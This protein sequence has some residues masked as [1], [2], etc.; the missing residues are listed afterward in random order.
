MAVLARHWTGNTVPLLLTV[1]GFVICG[2][3]IGDF[4]GAAGGR[5][6]DVCFVLEAPGTWLADVS[7]RR[8]AF[9][10]GATVEL[11]GDLAWVRKNRTGRS[12][13]RARR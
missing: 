5:E 1:S 3:T 2:A 6:F 7:G 4:V 11:L 10:R 8:L 9:G 12:A 13:E